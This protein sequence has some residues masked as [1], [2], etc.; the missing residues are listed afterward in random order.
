MFHTIATAVGHREEVSE[1]VPSA[2]RPP[3][4]AE[5]SITQNALGL[6]F[7]SDGKI[8]RAGL[9][10]PS[11]SE[12]PPLDMGCIARFRCRRGERRSPLRR[13]GPRHF[14]LDMGCIYRF[15]DE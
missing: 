10:P 4:R 14:P 8:C 3:D 6:F 7:E 9:T 5:P 1:T 11:M 2:T 12:A 15:R 13:R